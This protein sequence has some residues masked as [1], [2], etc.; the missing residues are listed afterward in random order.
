MN[1]VCMCVYPS[2]YI[3][4]KKTLGWMEKLLGVGIVKMSLLV[5]SVLSS[6]LC[7]MNSSNKIKKAHTYT[8]YV[9]MPGKLQTN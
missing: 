4:K 5:P 2:M 1:S 8:F 7:R 6:L 9:L 3:I